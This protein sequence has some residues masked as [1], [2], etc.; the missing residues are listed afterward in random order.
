[1]TD[2]IHVRP[3]QAEDLEAI[4]AICLK[5][6]DA[7]RDATALYRDPKLVGHIYGAP[8]VALGDTVSH[9]AAD[10]EGVLGY[11]VGVTDTRA[12]ERRL[13]LEWWPA[14]RRQYPD[15]PRDNDDEMHDAIRIGTIHHPVP[16]P[17]DIVGRFPAHI[18]MNLLPR[19]QGK[20]VGSRLLET[21]LAEARSQ[22]AT[23]VHAGVSAVNK[24][25]LAFWMAR[26]FEPVLKVLQSGSRGTIWCG[27]RI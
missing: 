27:R 21:W 15:M 2:D 13:E 22:G 18:H 8:Y 23:S 19:A 7:G 3:A 17:E 24:A 6:G 1:M 25:G 9:V 26:G 14:L 4:Y 10:A 16:V 11:A 5:T 12:F 20:G